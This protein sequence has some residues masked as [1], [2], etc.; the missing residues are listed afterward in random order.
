MI[1]IIGNTD[2]GVNREDDLTFVHSDDLMPVHSSD[3]L[4]SLTGSSVLAGL[5]VGGW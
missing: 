3:L 2:I 1:L 5:G 4:G